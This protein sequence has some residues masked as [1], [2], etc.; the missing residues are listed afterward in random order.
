MIDLAELRQ[1]YFAF[2]I[3]RD[4]EYQVA[5]LRLAVD[6]TVDQEQLDV[7]AI[8]SETGVHAV[9][10]GQTQHITHRDA[11]RAVGAKRRRG[12]RENTTKACRARRIVRRRTDRIAVLRLKDNLL[13]VVGHEVDARLIIFDA[14]RKLAIGAVAIGIGCSEGDLNVEE[15]DRV[16]RRFRTR[17]PRGFSLGRNRAIA[18]G[19]IVVEI[20]DQLK[21]VGAIGCRRIERD[22]EDRFAFD[23]IRE[24]GDRATVIFDTQRLE[25][26]VKE[27]LVCDQ[28]IAAIPL[29]VSAF[30]ILDTVGQRETVRTQTSETRNRCLDLSG[31]RGSIETREAD[32]TAD[33]IVPNR[34]T[35]FT[36]SFTLQIVVRSPAN[37]E[38]TFCPGSARRFAFGVGL[39]VRY[40]LYKP[41]LVAL[42]RET[43]FV[44]RTVDRG[45]NRRRIVLHV[46]IEGAGDTIPIA[47]GDRVGEAEAQEI[48]EIIL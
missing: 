28:L 35:V 30:R 14:N 45:A 48:I 13:L 15:I 1:R 16:A 19:R 34:L 17:Y 27:G 5:R 46:D 47:V 42:A 24:F 39:R 10:A 26:T 6:G 29:A 25:R 4:R 37:G 40:T 44:D 31:G 9:V 41:R 12:N 7:T 2:G 23:R 38:R 8:M 20:A 43:V 18:A 22:D 3:D 32:G 36:Q 11:T 33:R 21:G